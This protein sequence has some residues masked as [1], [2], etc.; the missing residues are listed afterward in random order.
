ML[1]SRVLI[2]ALLPLFIFMPNPPIHSLKASRYPEVGIAAEI[3]RARIEGGWR[4]RRFPGL[5][6]L[7][8]LE[9]G[10]CSSSHFSQGASTNL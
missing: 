9:I 5:I 3:L 10:A 7:V 6:L 1:A 4:K 8:W 2:E